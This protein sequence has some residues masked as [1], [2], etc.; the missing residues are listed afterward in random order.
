MS[1]NEAKAE[2]TKA[3]FESVKMGEGWPV[4]ADDNLNDS[5]RRLIAAIAD[6]N[7]EAW[8]GRINLYGSE[9]HGATPYI[10]KWDGSLVRNF[11]CAFVLPRYDA[12]VERMVRERDDAPYTTTADDATCVGDHRSDLGRR[13]PSPVLD[14]RRSKRHDVPSSGTLNK[15]SYCWRCGAPFNDDGPCPGRRPDMEAEDVRYAVINTWNG[16]VGGRVLMF[17]S[18][19]RGVEAQNECFEWIHKNTPFS[20]QEAVTHQG[21]KVEPW[22]E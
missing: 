12:E 22:E 16:G 14:V 2:H 3:F 18:E 5:C 11:S 17:V 13:R 20:F 21:Y 4:E 15:I 8:L 6:E 9:R 1:V 10:W 7:G 19:K